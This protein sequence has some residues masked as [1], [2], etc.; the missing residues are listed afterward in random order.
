MLWSACKKKHDG[1]PDAVAVTIPRY[2]VDFNTNTIDLSKVDSATITFNVGGLTIIK[3]MQREINGYSINN[4]TLSNEPTSVSVS[5]YTP[6]VDPTGQGGTS[7]GRI[8]VYDIVSNDV[9]TLTGPSVVNKDKWKPRVIVN[10]VV[11]HVSLTFG[12]NPDDPYFS[13]KA[14]NPAF[15][16]RCLL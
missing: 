14:D 5:V 8:F 3:K 9:F 11:H 10:D 12:E 1:N 7:S 2:E 15:G 13:I 6:T 4:V 16:H